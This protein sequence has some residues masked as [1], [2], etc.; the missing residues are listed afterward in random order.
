ML[1]QTLL[2][3]ECVGFKDSIQQLPLLRNF[4]R[5]MNHHNQKKITD[6]WDFFYGTR[7]S[8]ISI[9]AVIYCMCFFGVLSDITWNH[10]GQFL[11]LLLIYQ[12]VLLPY[13]PEKNP[14]VKP[15]QLSYAALFP[16]LIMEGVGELFVCCCFLINFSHLIATGWSSLLYCKCNK[17]IKQSYSVPLYFSCATEMHCHYCQKNYLGSDTW[18]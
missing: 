5:E 12:M 9:F 18:E 8:T 7:I 13:C 10:C 3:Q 11:L 15:R 14:S 2:Q 17:K 1:V 6:Y 4:W 16:F